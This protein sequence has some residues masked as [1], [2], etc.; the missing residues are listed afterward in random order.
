MKEIVEQALRDALAKLVESLDVEPPDFIE[1]DVPKKAEFGDFSSNIAMIIANRIKKPPREV[2]TLIVD[3]LTQGSSD[4][5][6][7]IEIKG[8]GFINFFI[9]HTQLVSR[10]KII[11]EMGED[12]G[13]TESGGGKRVLI[14]YVSANPTGFLH[15]GHARNA[16]VGSALTQILSFAGYEVSTEYYIN[17]AG[18]QID[19]LGSSVY[20]RYKQING[21]EVPLPPDG[22]HGDYIQ[23]IAQEIIGL[24]VDVKNDES[25][26][27]LCKT[28][29]I[30]KI[31]NQIK[32]SLDEFGVGFD[33]WYSEREMLLQNAGGEIAVVE[34]VKE[35][36]REAGALKEEDGALWFKATDYGQDQ[37]WVL[38]KSDGSGTYFL[39]DIAYHFEKYSRGYDWYIN[40]WGADHHG[41]IA[42]LKAALTAL[43]LDDSMLEVL[44]IQFVRLVSDGKEV[45]MSKRSGSFVTMTEVVDE[46]GKDV[47]RFFLLMRSSASHL[48]FDLALAKRESNENPVYYIQYANAR[49]NSV[50]EKAAERGLEPSERNL[51]LLD[52]EYEIEITKKLL[53]FPDLVQESANALSP[54]KIVFY[55]QDLASKFHIYYNNCRVLEDDLSLA[56]ARLYF[57][58]RIST[59]LKNGL[60]LL[61]VS[62]PDRM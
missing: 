8:P 51:E 42:R 49:I 40:I 26:K 1:I 60:N 31:Q 2:A 32:Q 17:D 48:D 16:A 29:A 57:I 37:D 45:K 28:F 62:I 3:T 44:L 22:Y 54:H 52:T 47:A 35:K 4:Y 23:D 41:H 6:K 61:G 7:K 43:G 59:V 18:N 25:L 50:F 11:R 53:S 36:L 38:V 55:L 56:K 33:K 20:A 34:M 10:L 19:M 14:E 15:I 5:F 58:G 12:F 24:K 39:S 13:K 9:D 46:V 30:E 21:E 27:E